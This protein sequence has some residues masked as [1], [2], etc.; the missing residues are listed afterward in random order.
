M[1]AHPRSPKGSFSRVSLPF[2]EKFLRFK[3]SYFSARVK[4]KRTG[5]R[6]LFS[7]RQLS[8]SSTKNSAIHPATIPEKPE[9][10][11]VSLNI[12]LVLTLRGFLAS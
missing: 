4:M 11:Y 10:F 5:I 1:C 3:K 6:V 8:T 2:F 12:S 9:T 7:V